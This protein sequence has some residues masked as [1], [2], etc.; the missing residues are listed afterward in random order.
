MR[1]LGLHDYRN[2][3]NK[4][5]LRKPINSSNP[6]SKSLFSHFNS[7]T[8]QNRYCYTYRPYLTHPHLHQCHHHQNSRLER[9]KQRI[10]DSYHIPFE[11]AFGDIPTVDQQIQS[12]IFNI[13]TMIPNQITEAIDEDNAPAISHLRQS[14][15]Q[16]YES[17]NDLMYMKKHQDEIYPHHHYRRQS[18]FSSSTIEK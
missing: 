6:D 5:D 14:L 8:H 17:L 18:E 15:Q 12:E 9:T 3:V 7:Q 1:S 13:F 4:N 16:S 10:R 11:F 2:E